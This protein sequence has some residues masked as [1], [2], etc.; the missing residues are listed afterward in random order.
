MKALS[1]TA[2]SV[3]PSSTLTLNAAVA[4]RRSRGDDIINLCVGE[5]DF[6]M[7]AE[8]AKAAVAAVERGES[9][10]TDVAGLPALRERLRHKFLT[11]N[12]LD[13]DPQQI[14]VSAG[15]KQALYNT[16]LALCGP[17]DDVLV[18]APYW[19]TYPEQ[20]RAVGAR[21][22]TVD[23]PPSAGYKLTPVALRA[24][25]TPRTKAVV[26]N[27]PGNP[28]GAAYSAAE[29]GELA[30]VIL[31]HDLFVVEDLVYEHFHYAGGPAPSIT[32]V[33][34][35]LRERTVVV[36]ALSKTC[37]MTGWRVG[38]SVAPP[39]L[40]ALICRL[41]GQ[42]TSNVTTVAQYAALAALDA[43]PW[44]AIAGYRARRDAAHAALVQVPGVRSA[45]PDGAFYLFADVRGILGGEHRG[46]PLV[47]SEDLC[48]AVLESTGVAMM[49]GEPFGA[50]GHARI[51]YSAAQDDVVRG[52]R[53]F[54]E[55]AD[56]VR[57]GSRP[58]VT[59]AHPTTSPR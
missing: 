48:A 3:R 8:A 15:A 29:L 13:V 36:D 50:P 2:L 43:V 24:G 32:T 45:L 17:G 9:R 31:E 30:E 20:V 21:P 35:H 26:I 4:A 46:T 33:G 41:Q 57:P 34:P 40:S 42:I 1:A 39:A 5:V 44:S 14:V 6:P 53:R 55:F 51:S 18:P 25:L 7:P 54:A 49:P 10:Y 38:Y 56:L 11:E 12:G 59:D 23:C 47:T 27:S 16:F 37:G 28:T 22:V 19:V 52:L 58:A